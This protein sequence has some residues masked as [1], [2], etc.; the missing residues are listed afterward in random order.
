M[1]NAMTSVHK[2]DEKSPGGGTCHP[3]RVVSGD[4]P[5]EMRSELDSKESA[6]TLIVKNMGVHSGDR[7]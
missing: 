5:E 3:L 4:C 1:I 6:V 2:R 7:G